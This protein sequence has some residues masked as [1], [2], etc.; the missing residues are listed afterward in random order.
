MR[1]IVKQSFA[2]VLAAAVV[3]GSMPAAAMDVFAAEAENQQMAGISLETTRIVNLKTEGKENPIGVDVSS[4]V[5]SWQMTSDAVGVSQASYQLIVT[6]A[7]DNTVVWETGEVNSEDSAAV[8]YEGSSL[9]ACTE[10]NWSVIV[11]DNFGNEIVSGLAQFETS[12]LSTELSAWDGAEWIGADELSVDAAASTLFN[13]TTKVQI[14]SGS[15]GASVIFGADDF[16]LKNKLF[17]IDMMEGENYFRVELDISQVNEN[18]GAAINIY[19]VGYFDGDTEDQ[20]FM[21][22]NKAN[23]PVTNLD[24][25]ITDENKN[26]Q[27][28]LEFNVVTSTL[29]ISVDG[30]EIAVS[31]PTNG[32]GTS[33]SIVLSKLGNSN[34][35]TFPNLNSI[36]FAADAGQK[37]VFTDFELQNPGFGTGTLFGEKTGASY[38]IWKDKEGITL[39]GNKITVE[40]TD[41]DVVAYGDPSYASEPY[42][43][44]DF[45][46]D[47]QIESARL[48]MGIQGIG[49]F[50]INGEEVA[51]DE[52]FKQGSM[53][54]REEIGYNVYDVT[55]Y[56]TQG[57][58]AMGAVLGEG[59]WTGHA[60]TF[61]DSTY[62]YYGDQ[63]ALLV[64]LVVKYMD[65]TSETIVTDDDTWQYFG[66]G[67]VRLASLF[68]GERYDATKEAEIEGFTKADYNPEAAGWRMAETVETRSPFADQDLVVRHDD[69]VHVI[70][71]LSADLIGENK[72]GSGS[73]IYDFGENVAA[74]PQITIP[75]EYAEEGET[76]TIRVAEMLYP[77]L[78]EYGDLAGN[79]LQENYRAALTTDFYTMKDGEQTYVPD[80]TFHGYRYIEITGLREALPAEYV[81]SLVLSSIE[82]TATFDSSNDLV[83][84]LFINGQNSEAS[85]YITL[86]TDCPQRNERMGWMG[87]ANV[88]ALAG[89]YNANTYQFLR[90]WLNCVRQTQGEDGMTGHVS[91]NYPAFNLETGEV[92]VGGMS[93]GITWNSA[94]VF[95]PYFLY[96]QY[97]DT[98]IVQENMDAIYAY[99]EN[100]EGKPLSFEL[101]G[102]K[103]TEPALT[104]QTG[105]LC[106]HLSVVDTDGAMLGNAMYVYCL[107]STA[108]MAKALGQ[109][110][111]AEKYTAMHE[112][113][114]EAWNQIY[115]DSETGKSCSANGSIIHTQA[116]YASPINYGVVN[117]DNLD[118]YLENYI[119]TIEHPVAND[120][121]S[122]I[123]YTITTGFNATPNL[124]NALSDHGRSDAAYKMFECTDYASWLYP[125]TQGATSIWERWDSYT[126]E[127]GFGGNNSMNSFNHY[128]LGAV[129]SW[130][131]D[132]QLGIKYD[133]KAPGYKHFILQPTAGGSFTYAN[134]TFDSAYGTIYSGWTADSKEMTA[135]EAVVP[136]NTTATLYLPVNKNQSDCMVLPEGAALIGFEEHNGM[137]CAKIELLSGTYS[138]DIPT[139]EDAAAIISQ[140]AQEKAEAAKK[141]AEEARKEAEAAKKESVEAN[142]KAEEAR[143]A[144]EA[145]K[146]ESGENSAK[147]KAAL[148]AAQRAEKIAEEARVKVERL[149][150]KAIKPSVKTIKSTKKKYVKV[151]WKKV[152]SADGY[153]IQYSLKSN[154]AGKKSL[155]IKKRTTLTKTNKKLKSGKKYYFR[156]RAYK[157]IGG[158]KV[159]TSYSNKKSVKVK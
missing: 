25:L 43:R 14:P 30:Q 5:F 48:Y 103:Y 153:I 87:D 84:R 97:G 83:N 155:T 140:K 158:K 29:T 107:E 143:K 91:P 8:S 53:E 98:T 37:A 69:E 105:F 16:R 41:K 132:S 6:K 145:A 39:E 63:E 19:R 156:I 50:Y 47:S 88:Y 99:M 73:Y 131:M 135:Y 106:D 21:V 101:N 58:N 109:T 22:I 33:G 157:T 66:D 18:G 52:W 126:Q 147:A 7:T 10:Y 38:N 3:T 79:L 89:S 152:S 59:W 121:S 55:D 9:E 118:R 15:T 138:F 137:K 149:E 102:A 92:K 114:K 42:L 85:N 144:A 74:V 81:K 20:T 12:L 56:L 72:S 136:A 93:F 154:F 142:K 139:K 82:N 123:P 54:Y 133:E 68:E 125:V 27:H 40:G 49:D 34:A 13:I 129:T 119:D 100:L 148:E 11:K 130:M 95:I 26:E 90:Q 31:E 60:C 44:T 113:A 94:I 36:G 80:L 110:D 65:G 141:E 28:T 76:I 51:P 1:K 108:A 67:P 117:E 32:G 128:S 75:S 2:Y 115:I 61:S 77:E 124:L 45:S 70:N 150:F 57:E 134:G 116:S 104:S 159:Y 62:N 96:Q 86:P 4:P 120:G 71:T 122:L 127:N 146:K 24:E 17:N 23:N 151:T 46:L 112:A 78:G 111:K 64:K 35:M